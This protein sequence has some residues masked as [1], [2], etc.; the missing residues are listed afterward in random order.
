MPGTMTPGQMFDHELNP[1]KGWPSPY[2]IDYAAPVSSSEINTIYAG[3]GCYLDAN[4][5]FR[6]GSVD[7]AVTILMFQG[8]NDFDANSDIGNI[9]GGVMS[10]L[11][12]VASYEVWTTE[13]V[14]GNYL[15]NDYLT[16]VASGDNIGK[17]TEGNAYINQI[18]GIVSKGT[19]TNENQ[20]SAL[21]F[22]T[23]HLPPMTSS[24]SSS[25]S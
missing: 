18:C 15:P 3:M 6:L 9:S 1:V 14:A 4:G 11:P 20:K 17:V 16:V 24:S 25:S 23:Y 5:E 13:F 10:G 2:A 19:F 8:Q 7:G 22:W 21:Q 12:C